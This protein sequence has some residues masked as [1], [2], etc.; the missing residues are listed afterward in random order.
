MSNEKKEEKKQEVLEPTGPLCACG[1]PVAP[2]QN[3]VCKD[4]IRAN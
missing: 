3:E 4:H 2:G 1:Q